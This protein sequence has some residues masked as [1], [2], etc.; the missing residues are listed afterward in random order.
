MMSYP[1]Q[2]MTGLALCVVASRCSNFTYVHRDL[3]TGEM[4]AL[5]VTV[6]IAKAEKE[7]HRRFGGYAPLGD[8]LEMSP[9]RTARLVKNIGKYGYQASLEVARDRFSVT[10]AP[11]HAAGTEPAGR[12]SFYVD[13]TY[14]VRYS[15]L[16]T[17][18]NRTSP[19]LR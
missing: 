5:R 19:E 11:V 16:P 1:A 2:L 4:Y 15:W 6:D 3:V 14:I 17:I 9:E 18:A 13:Q 7:Y 12:R 10:T 8:I